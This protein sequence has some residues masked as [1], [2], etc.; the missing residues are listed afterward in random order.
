VVRRDLQPSLP[1][2]PTQPVE[3]LVSLH[4]IHTLPNWQSAIE[5]RDPL[6]VVTS[7]DPWNYA[8]QIPVRVEGHLAEDRWYWI[9]IDLQVMSGQ[10]GI[11][12]LTDGEIQ[13]E[14]LVLAGEGQTSVVVRVC[15]RL[16]SVVMIRNGSL[17][18]RSV[19]Q[20]FRVAAESCRR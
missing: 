11:G 2:V 4:D 17:P 10:V 15:H 20:I 1:S 13:D 19:V 9:R 8:A 7:K 3:A 12:L 14:R 16:T 5:R 6:K 18:G